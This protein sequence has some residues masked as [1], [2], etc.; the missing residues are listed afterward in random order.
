MFDGVQQNC[1]G[2]VKVVLWVLGGHVTE[3]RREGGQRW[4]AV[5]W[6]ARCLWYFAPW[7]VE[8]LQVQT[9]TPTPNTNTGRYTIEI[10]RGSSVLGEG[11]VPGT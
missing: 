7:G 10:P 2:C 9:N 11:V 6:C 3:E 1:K 5:Q 4:C 8:M